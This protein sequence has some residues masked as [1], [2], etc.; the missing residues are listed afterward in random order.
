[1]NFTA[2]GFGVLPQ[3]VYYFAW[4]IVNLYNVYSLNK[5]GLPTCLTN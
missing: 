2:F 3:T 4:K 5:T 1:M